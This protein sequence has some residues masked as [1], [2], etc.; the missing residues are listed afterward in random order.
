M[1]AYVVAAALVLTSI[2]GSAEA[3]ASGSVEVPATFNHAARVAADSSGRSYVAAFDDAAEDIVVA[4]FKTDGLLDTEFGEG[5][6]ARH[7]QSLLAVNAPG[8]V[9]IEAGSEAVFVRHGGVVY[10]LSPDGAL[11]WETAV[12]RCNGPGVPTLSLAPDESVLWTGALDDG[13]C[14]A[15]TIGVIEA[16]GSALKQGNLPLLA[17]A[18][19]APN[20]AQVWVVDTDEAALAGYGDQT[21]DGTPPVHDVVIEARITY[22][23]EL[24]F[25]REDPLPVTIDPEGRLLVAGE[26]HNGGA[27]HTEVALFRMSE[28]GIDDSFGVSGATEISTGKPVMGLGSDSSGRI[29]VAVSKAGEGELHGFTPDGAVDELFGVGGIFSVA[30]AIDDA[31]MVGDMLA[32]AWIDGSTINLDMIPIGPTP[33]VNTFVDD[34]DSIFEQDIEWL[35]AAGI[36]M[37][38]NPPDFDQFCPGDNITRGQMAAFLVRALGLVDDGGGNYF[39]D[40]DDSVFEQDIAILAAAGITKGCQSPA[41]DKFCPGDFVTR[42]QMAAFLARALRLDDEGGGDH[43]VDDDGHIFE[44]EIAMLATAEITAGCNPPDYDEYCPDAL[45]T[46]AQMAAFLHRGLAGEQGRASNQPEP[47]P[48][49]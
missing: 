9:D 45:V 32:I 30:H 4:R 2:L 47:S 5:G 29:V 1:S 14:A 38:C 25:L 7:P 12:P 35:A 37:G 8:E 31:V 6:V 18:V 33:P 39:V 40:D 42:G 10:A 16:S 22:P 36:T 13:P 17:F 28:S 19:A 23:V 49:S 46:R 3:A 24:D 48:Q 41:K 43:F 21:S 11:M 44:S 20:T 15:G 27:P 34:D 26:V